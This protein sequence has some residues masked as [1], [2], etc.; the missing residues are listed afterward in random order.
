LI[1]KGRTLGWDTG[2][3]LRRRCWRRL[4]CPSADRRGDANGA[5]NLGGL[6]A[7]EGKFED[8]LRAYERADRRGD[9]AAATRLGTMLRQR[10]DYDG[11]LAAYRR[12]DARGDADGAFHL[13][14]M[15]AERGEWKAAV[16]AHRRSAKRSGPMAASVLRVLFEQHRNKGTLLLPTAARGRAV[17]ARWKRAIPPSPPN[18]G[19]TEWR[20]Q[21]G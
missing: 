10:G 16:A 8:A 9:P 21:P 15:L 13:G 14:E 4:C 18:I 1:A 3:R 12:A 11:A 17:A 6:L 2:W 7:E 5:F 20:V 19:V